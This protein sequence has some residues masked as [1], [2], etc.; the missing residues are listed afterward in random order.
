MLHPTVTERIR[1]IFL[2]DEARVTIEDAARMLG[3][4]GWEIAAAIKD[5]EIEATSGAAGR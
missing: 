4:S 3:R 2:H 5:G 1:S